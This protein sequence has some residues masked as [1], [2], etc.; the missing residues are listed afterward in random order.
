MGSKHIW[1][2]TAWEGGIKAAKATVWRKAMRSTEKRKKRTLRIEYL[3]SW[4]PH[5]SVLNSEQ[6]S[7]KQPDVKKYYEK[8]RVRRDSMEIVD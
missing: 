8:Y 6:A 7:R 3:R 2:G 5:F 4:A 1:K